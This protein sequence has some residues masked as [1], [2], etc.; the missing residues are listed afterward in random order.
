MCILS[1]SSVQHIFDKILTKIKSMLNE[2]EIMKKINLKEYYPGIYDN[3]SWIE[4]EDDIF[5]VFKE[6]ERKEAAYYRKMYRYKAQYSMCREDGIEEMASLLAENTSPESQVERKW[7]TEQIF[8]AMSSIPDKQASRL[9]AH[10]F[11]GLRVTEIAEAEGV[12][13]SRVSESIKAG[14]KNVGT[15][16]NFL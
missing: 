14:L 12:S 10:F 15:L 3:D 4:V 2:G 7:L 8:I 6:F 16:L 13:K 1:F 11:L 5:D 9:Y